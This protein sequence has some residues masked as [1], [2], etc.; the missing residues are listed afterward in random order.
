[1]SSLNVVSTKK[2]FILL[3]QYALY[4]N[5]YDPNGFDG[6]YGNGAKSAVTKFQ[7]FCALSADGIAGII[8]GVAYIVEFIITLLSQLITKMA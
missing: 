6:Y 2:N 3:L 4:C 7:S 5:G 8:D 1:M